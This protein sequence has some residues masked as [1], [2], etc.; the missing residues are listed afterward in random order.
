MSKKYLEKNVYDAAIER[1]NLVFDEF[2]RICVSFSGGKDSTVLL[3]LT[4]KVAQ[5]RGRLP[6]DVLFIDLEGQF[7]TT[8]DHIVEMLNLPGIN[9]WWICLPLNLRNAVSV[10]D[11][12][13]CCWDPEEQANWV[14]PLP[15]H[16][17]VIS[18]PKHFPWF[19]H[20]ME[21]EEF[22][23]KFPQSIA[24]GKPYASLVAIRADESLHRYIAVAKEFGEKKSA[25]QS[26]KGK[27]IKWGTVLSP[28]T[29]NIVNLYPIYDWRVEDIWAYIGKQKLPYNHLYDQMYL[30]G[31]PLSEM[32]ICQPYG[33][34]QRKGL[35]LWHKV[36]PDTW[37]RVLDRVTGANY[38]SRYARQKMLGYH[39]GL[40]VPEGH[41]WKSY[42]FFLLSTLPDVMRE[43]YLSNFAVFLEW[44]MRHGYPSFDSVFDDETL[45][46]K[47]S[48]RRRL[49]SWRRLAL[50][51]MKNDFLCK[52][53]SIGQIKY[54]F[55]DVY[56]RVKNGQPVKV[57]KSVKPVYDYLRDQYQQF[58]QN[59][60]EKV[61]INFSSKS[62]LA[63]IKRRYEDL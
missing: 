22:I 58:L 63:E 42:T 41:S 44:W 21:F 43:R 52:T 37:F 46:L 55:D 32:R 16:S 4:L 2:E 27:E 18:N 35:D 40:K 5:D 36:E 24:D 39:R 56:E 9:P 25:Y 15:E 54:V 50:A 11:P 14:R 59:G 60:I 53:L 20:R 30:A 12:H 7:Q 61:T 8:I 31:M 6:I 10:F 28:K 51:I 29:P 34:D 17:S 48:G 45:Y 62:N 3:H 38:G 57:R 26:R 1:L 47:D 19:R 23:V 33:D 49:P 13:W